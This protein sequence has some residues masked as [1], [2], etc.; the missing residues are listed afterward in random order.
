MDGLHVVHVIDS[1]VPGGAEMSL[2]AMAPE[3]VRRG[4]RLDVIALKT[5]P[6]L[7]DGLVNAGATVTELAGSRRTWWRSVAELVREL[8][9]DLVH[10]TLFEADIA[11]RIGARL[12]STTAL[13]N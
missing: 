6:G 4:T 2:A 3:L 12:A 5:R 8:R 1:L 10:T 7:R 11:G 13:S 9:P